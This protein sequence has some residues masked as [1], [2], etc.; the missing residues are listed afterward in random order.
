MEVLKCCCGKQAQEFTSWTDANPWRCFFG[1]VKY[2][3]GQGCNFFQWIDPRMGERSRT[4]IPGLLRKLLVLT[5][6]G[7]SI[8]FFDYELLVLIAIGSIEGFDSCI[9]QTIVYA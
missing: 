1:C 9:H 6:I 3:R 5:A 7:A 4:V 8:E 2:G